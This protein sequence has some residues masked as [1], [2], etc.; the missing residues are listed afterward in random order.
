M[1]DR[2]LDIAT[3]DGAMNTFITHPEEGAPTRLSSFT[4]TH[5]AN[6]K[7]CTTWRGALVQRG[8]T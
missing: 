3:P 4:W 6:A 7:S 2:E 8:I 1:I 5:P